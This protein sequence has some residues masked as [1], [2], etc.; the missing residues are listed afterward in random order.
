VSSIWGGLFLAGI[1][2]VQRFLPKQ[3]F[4]NYWADGA[5]QGFA[6]LVL[7]TLAVGALY[8]LAARWMPFAA[9]T[10]VADRRLR[11]KALTWLSL[12]VC[13]GIYEA[14]AYPLI[15][16]WQSMTGPTV[17]WGALWGGVGGLAGITLSFI[18]YI[19]IP[20]IRIGIK[21]ESK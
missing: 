10:L 15:N 14:A 12:S 2:A 1:F 3:F 20:S 21:L 11:L 16:L 6:S 13:L 4:F 5:I 9:V 17:F 7:P 18:A 8:T 19:L